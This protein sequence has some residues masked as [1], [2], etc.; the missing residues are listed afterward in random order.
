[1]PDISIRMSDVRVK[2]FKNRDEIF[3]PFYTKEDGIV[4]CKNINGL[5]H[6]L[7]V[8][9]NPNEWRFFLDASKSGLK[10]VC[11]TMVISIQ[12]YL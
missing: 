2:Q 12:K 11:V 9:Y 3:R 1:M 4:F 8:D 5:M 7:N 6:L 10:G